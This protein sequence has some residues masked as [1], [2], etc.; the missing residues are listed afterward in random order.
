MHDLFLNGLKKIADVKLISKYKN[1]KIGFPYG[2]D[3]RIFFPDFHMYSKERQ[4]SMK[5]SCYTNY[6]ESADDLL[7][8]LL[9]YL[10]QFKS[11][12]DVPNAFIYQVG[13]F[14][15]YW[16]EVYL[17]S[18]KTSDELNGIT[19]NIAQSNSFSFNLMVGNDL[20]TNFLLGNHDFDLNRTPPYASKWR[21]QM[22]FIKSQLNEPLIGVF[23]GDIFSSSERLPKWVNEFAV[24]LFSPKEVAANAPKAMAAYKN[25]I[26]KYHK[27]NDYY[28]DNSN[29]QDKEPPTDLG[30]LTYPETPASEWNVFRENSNDKAKLKFFSVSKTLMDQ[31]NTLKGY[32]LRCAF[33]GHTHTP[34]IVVSDN[35]ENFFV[36]AD[37]GCWI[38]NCHAKYIKQ[39][40]ETIEINE[41]S[42]HI[43]VLSDNE[44][45]I[46][47]LQLKLV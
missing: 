4:R 17:P 23:H 15:D 2:D 27:E 46:Y 32:Q 45:R 19:A 34:R 43:G 20:K 41:K 13:D 18:N 8:V 37:F 29:A 1:E 28:K 40:G 47:Q 39:D 7:P 16:R 6:N 10:I 5:Y 12:P 38:K 25:N 36:L 24:Y 44:I 42:A 30:Y 35:N 3:I 11:S 26:K 21:S 33:I 31:I 22:V 14:L 9:R